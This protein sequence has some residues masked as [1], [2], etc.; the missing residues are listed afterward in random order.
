MCKLF[1]GGLKRDTQEDVFRKYFEKYGK[2]TD[3]VIICDKDRIS[4]GFGFVS[5]ETPEILDQVLISRP[6]VVD[7]KEVNNNLL[8]L[9]KKVD[10]RRATPK[11]Q[12]GGSQLPRTKK[13]F[14]GGLP[15]DVDINEIKVKIKKI[16]NKIGIF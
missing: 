2:L 3:C 8:K 6:H 7:E 1:I 13:V 14:I 9:K 12:M 16:I 11:N 10:I 5:Y 4:R 15:Q